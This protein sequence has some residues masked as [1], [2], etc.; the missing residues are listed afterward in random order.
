[1]LV[2]YT[3]LLDAHIRHARVEKLLQSVS[4]LGRSVVE[5]FDLIPGDAMIREFI[6]GGSVKIPHNE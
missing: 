2:Q 3:S 4:S 5:G 1:D 6:G